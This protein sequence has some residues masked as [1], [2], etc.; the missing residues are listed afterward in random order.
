MVDQYLGCLLEGIFWEYRP[1]GGHFES[2]LFIVRLL[3]HTI[4]LDRIFDILDR[5]VDR[6]QSDDRGVGP[7]LLEEF[8]VLI[9]RNPAAT[10]VDG[11]IHRELRVRVE[12][13]DNEFGVQNFEPGES[14]TQV[15]GF[16]HVGSRDFHATGFGL[17]F[18]SR[19][20]EADLL[21]VKD[22][23]CDVF[24][25]PRD[26]SQLMSNT[27]DAYRVDGEATKTRK[28]DAPKSI[29]D[30]LA[31]TGFQRTKLEL[32]ELR[33]LFQHDDLFGFLKC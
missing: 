9:G 17:V 4:I 26:G 23:V 14:F 19:L 25:N 27:V 29:A 32:A 1:V 24:L 33:V 2:K 21:Q 22:D 6:I 16:E 8:A 30:C 18:V 5:G 3:L 31:V 12:V 7:L 15:A 13:A 11:E 28:E 10:L 20:L